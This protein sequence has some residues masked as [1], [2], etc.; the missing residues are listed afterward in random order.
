MTGLCYYNIKEY[1]TTHYQLAVLEESEMN[2]SIAVWT[3]LIWK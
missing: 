1:F 2:L 3:V